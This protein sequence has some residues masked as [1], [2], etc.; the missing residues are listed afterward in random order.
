M[1][2]MLALK[3][4]WLSYILM[5]MIGLAWARGKVWNSQSRNHLYKMPTSISEVDTEHRRRFQS[6]SYRVFYSGSAVIG[7]RG[8]GGL[9]PADDP[10]AAK[11]EIGNSSAVT[12]EGSDFSPPAAEECQP[13]I[14]IVTSDSISS[15]KP[16][17][18]LEEGV[19]S[20]RGIAQ[21]ATNSSPPNLTDQESLECGK[22]TSDGIHSNHFAGMDENQHELETNHSEAVEEGSSMLPSDSFGF[23]HPREKED[24]DEELFPT[25]QLVVKCVHYNDR[26]G[27]W[28]FNVGRPNE[29]TNS[30]VSDT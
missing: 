15:N 30:T 1:Y 24:D 26:V 8:G 16:T 14:T 29:L 28:F 5:W 4:W 10:L 13:N 25:H 20:K 27:L 9:Y 6:P 17:F 11:G 3:A 12:C 21:T 18:V 7:F 19:D 2:R 23:P 22:S